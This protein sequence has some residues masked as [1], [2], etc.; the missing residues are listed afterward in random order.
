MNKI[1][2]TLGNKDLAIAREISLAHYAR[3]DSRGYRQLRR[4]RSRSDICIKF[5]GIKGEVAAAKVLGCAPPEDKPFDD[6]VDLVW[7]PSWSSKPFTIAVKT[8]ARPHT[9]PRLYFKGH[10]DFTANVGVLMMPLEDP[11]HRE[12]AF[13]GLISR[14]RFFDE[15]KWLQFP[16]GDRVVAVGAST[17]RFPSGLHWPELP[18]AED[19]VDPGPTPEKLVK[20]KRR[21][22]RIHAEG[23][24]WRSTGII[25]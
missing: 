20:Y 18:P 4:D 8:L 6:G 2:V 24:K 7:S 9:V 19:L 22:D 5:I 14:A 17:L 13:L 15:F 11:P 12:F 16:R 3:A 1:E 25:T 10:S 23:D 21:W